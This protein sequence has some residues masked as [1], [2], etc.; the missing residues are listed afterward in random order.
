[1]V[2]M[3][4]LSP[5]TALCTA[6]R[7]A[8]SADY[9]EAARSF[10]AAARTYGLEVDSHHHPKHGPHGEA[11]ACDTVW[12]GPRAA[13]RVL[14]VVS[15]VHGVEGF[16][17]SAI[18][19]DWLLAGGADS[20][21]DNVGVLLVHAIN[22][23]G[24]AW[25]RRVTEDGVDL[26]RNFVDFDAPLP[27]DEGYAALATAAVPPAFDGPRREAADAR[28]HEAIA[29]QG[30]SAV[31]TALSSGQYTHPRG[32]F[33]GGK[34]ATWSRRTL[35][36]LAGEHG[37]ADRS[38]LCVI[39]LHSGL[40]PFGYGELI[41]D[42]PPGSRSTALAR[43]WFGA[44]VTEPL[45]GTSTSPPK[46]GLADYFWHTLA[47]DHGC[48]L[49]LEFGTWPFAEILDALR[50]DHWLAATVRRC[51][52]IDWGAARTRAI[53]GRL[54]RAFFPDT[55]DWREMVL[56]RGRQVLRQALAGLSA[57]VA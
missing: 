17:G 40:G 7:V 9:E 34:A 20:L 2:A 56:F 8:F 33:Y 44:S 42:H 52:D 12:V 24:F 26:N 55:D 50:D 5:P 27:A 30:E 46:R 48:M 1:M 28:L 51:D 32:L 16:G 39:D 41:C 18:Q 4:Q 43:E 3:F 11:L 45:L 13:R 53:K 21:P 57:V 23:Y 47:G 36:S 14:V 37:L 29:A 49:T 19:I 15:G 6:A 54:R 25:L 22:P 38:A 31:A 35:E 10:R